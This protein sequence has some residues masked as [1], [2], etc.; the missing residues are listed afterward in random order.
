MTMS[1]VILLLILLNRAAGDRFTA[2]CRYILWCIVMIRLAIPVGA[3]FHTALIRLEVPVEREVILQTESDD[4][5]AAETSTPAAESGESAVSVL[6]SEI[7]ETAGTIRPGETVLTDDNGISSSALESF[8][9]VLISE[10]EE[11]IGN[12]PESV[13]YQET[14]IGIQNSSDAGTD[15]EQKYDIRMLLKWGEAAY[16]A[17]AVMFFAI[18]FADHLCRTKSLR[19]SRRTVSHELNEVYLRQCRECGVRKRPGLYASV[20]VSSP[21]LFGYFRPCILLPMNV[22]DPEKASGILRHELTHWKRGDLWIKLICLIAQSVHWINPLVHFAAGKC[23]RE[24]E[25]SCDEKVL[26]GLD[27]SE[28]QEYGMVMLDVVRFCRSRHSGLTTQFNPKRNVVFERFENILDMRRKN[29]GAVLIA[30]VMLVCLSAGM[31][32]SC[33]VQSDNITD[34]SASGQSVTETDETAGGEKKPIDPAL[35]NE[36]YKNDKPVGTVRTVSGEEM[37]RVNHAFAAAEKLKN[38]YRIEYQDMLDC[39]TAWYSNAEKTAEPYEN[40]ET[41]AKNKHGYADRARIYREEFLRAAEYLEKQVPGILFC[42]DALRILLSADHIDQTVIL[43][44]SSETEFAVFYRKNGDSAEELFRIIRLTTEE[45]IPVEESEMDT[46]Y[47]ACDGQH[48]YAI[49]YPYHVKDELRDTVIQSVRNTFVRCNERLK[50]VTSSKVNTIARDLKDAPYSLCWS[51]IANGMWR[52]SDVIHSDAVKGMSAKL[53]NRILEYMEEGKNVTGIQVTGVELNGTTAASAV[54]EVPEDLEICKPLA[55]ETMDSYF[56]PNRYNPDGLTYAIPMGDYTM[57]LDFILS[58]SQIRVQHIRLTENARLP[59]YEYNTPARELYAL[60]EAGKLT[61]AQ[62]MQYPAAQYDLLQIVQEAMDNVENNDTKNREGYSVATLSEGQQ[63]HYP[64]PAGIAEYYRGYTDDGITY[65][66]KCASGIYARIDVTVDGRMEFESLSMGN[67][68]DLITDYGSL[69]A[70]YHSG[71][72]DRL[73]LYSHETVSEMG[74]ELVN[75]VL[76]AFRRGENPNTLFGGASYGENVIYPSWVPIIEDV[77]AEQMSGYLVQSSDFNMMK[78]PCACYQVPLNT[79]ENLDIWFELYEDGMRGICVRMADYGTGIS[80]T[81]PKANIYQRV[82]EGK[83]SLNSVI[84]MATVLSDLR[85]IFSET[86]KPLVGKRFAG[87]AEEPDPSAI[88]F[89]NGVMP[90]LLAV[91]GMGNPALCYS[92]DGETVYEVGLKLISDERTSRLE[93][94]YLTVKKAGES[95]FTVLTDCY[96]EGKQ[97]DCALNLP[98]VYGFDTVKIHGI[99]GSGDGEVCIAE[100]IRGSESVFILADV[101]ET[102]GKTLVCRADDTPKTV[103]REEALAMKLK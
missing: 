4:G 29:R 71:Q 39:L 93:A 50:T 43:P 16:L 45:L 58:E 15:P 65:I 5:G 46:T 69:Y 62:L 54:L 96:V 52:K 13:L 59:Q 6:Q 28:R 67:I 89:T 21:I 92:P 51:H 64:T 3:P 101:T 57:F 49:Q 94:S 18:R 99:S 103:T 40:A 79:T 53:V 75:S 25:L 42:R 95:R 44:G 34:L 8:T 26:D 1:A 41:N 82:R 80:S 2:R 11:D 98:Q 68:T 10:T 47:F 90:R 12:L 102:V 66:Y 24:M 63:L 37:E 23:V 88:T 81:A 84:G 78:H 35:V 85:E 100:L 17:V 55:A 70:I 33:T 38:E 87:V 27:R 83:T 56:V 32:L 86:M 97:T 60:F 9:S 36:S 74:A 91:S 14:D 77:Q 31:I 22:Q 48:Y 72:I 30:A 61:S 19:S 73:Q 20:R 7:P 76:A